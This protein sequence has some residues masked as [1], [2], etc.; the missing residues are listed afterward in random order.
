MKRCLVMKSALGKV[1]LLTTGFVVLSLLASGCTRQDTEAEAAKTSPEAAQ[2]EKPSEE[3]PVRV[4]AM[5]PVVPSETAEEKATVEEKYEK[6]IVET[7]VAAGNFKTLAKALK[8]AELIEMLKSEGPFTVFAP[9][10]EAFEALPPGTLDKLL[11]DPEKLKRIL[12]YHVVRGKV[13]SKEAAKLDRA[14]SA[15]GSPLAL[16]FRRKRVWVNDAGVIKADILA[17][18][19]VIHM[20]DR[21]ILPPERLKNILETAAEEGTFKTWARALVIAKLADTLKSEGPFTVFAPTDEAFKA[22]PEGELEELLKDPERLKRVLLYHVV[23]GKVLAENVAKLKEA[24]TA[25]GDPLAIKIR[26]QRIWINDA[27]VVRTDI[28][29]TNGVIHVIDKVIMPPEKMKDLFQTA[30]EVGA[31]ETFVKALTT[32]KLVETLKSEGPF[33]VFAPTDEAF[34]ALPEGALDELLKDPERL[35]RVLLYHVIPRKMLAEEVTRTDQAET[36]QGAPVMFKVLDGRAMI[37]DARIIQTDVTADNGVIHIIDK[38]IMPP[39]E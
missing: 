13:L 33:T 27:S 11:K 26:G 21:V 15:E 9:T 29:T 28:L 12:L 6:D 32:A 39:A 1:L 37:N 18:N 7:A 10:D 35:K 8:A 16:K 20:I 34:A 5:K 25:M 23:P 2:T 30:M 19:G 38:V 22:L 3:G 36:V 24:D 14:D 31:F 4:T 17:S